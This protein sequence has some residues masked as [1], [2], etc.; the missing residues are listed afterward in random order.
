MRVIGGTLDST[1]PEELHAIK[2]ASQL[3]LSH[4]E[5]AGTATAQDNSSSWRTSHDMT[6]DSGFEL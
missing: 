6:N 4:L 2:E 5:D 3:D 1:A